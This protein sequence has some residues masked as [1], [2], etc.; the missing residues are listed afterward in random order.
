MDMNVQNKYK[1][2]SAGQSNLNKAGT[3][4][5]QI[6]TELDTYDDPNHLIHDINKWLE[7]VISKN[8]KEFYDKNLKL[9]LSEIS[10]TKNNNNTNNVPML[11]LSDDPINNVTLAMM[12]KVQLLA[13]S[14]NFKLF[15]G[16]LDRDNKAVIAPELNPMLT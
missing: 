5:L 11:L 15:Y 7:D 13:I 2:L 4:N 6:I 10:C 9:L 12:Q 3:F 1:G 16:V 14:R 8:N